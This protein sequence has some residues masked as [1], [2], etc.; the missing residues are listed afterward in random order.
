MTQG[1]LGVYDL[2]AA[3]LALGGVNDV[4]VGAKRALGIGDP[5]LLERRAS[6]L[7]RAC[8]VALEALDVGLHNW[9]R[10][11][12]ATLGLGPDAEPDPETLEPVLAA[13]GL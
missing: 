11:E 12:R 8:G 7:A 10:A 3:S 9:Q 5:L 13:V 4:T 2:L 1:R 6:D